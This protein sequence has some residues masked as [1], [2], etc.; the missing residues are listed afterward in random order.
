MA[1]KQ[2]MKVYHGVP[3]SV[4][5]KYTIYYDSFDGVNTT[6]LNNEYTFVNSPTGYG[7]KVSDT[8]YVG[9][10]IPIINNG[11]ESHTLECWFYSGTNSADIFN[12]EDKSTSDNL[13]NRSATLYYTKTS[14]I[15]LTYFDIDSY[16]Q[17]RTITVPNT[18]NIG[19]IHVRLTVVGHVMSL[20]VNGKLHSEVLTKLRPFN[21]VWV[22]S[23]IGFG[24]S[25][26]K[27]PIISDLR[28]SNVDRGNYFPNLPQDF[29][30]GKAAIK[31][32]MNQQQIKGD[33]MYTQVTTAQIPA[34]NTKSAELYCLNADRSKGYLKGSPEIF[35]VV[36]ANT[37]GKGSSFKIRGVNGEVVAGIVD[38]NAA[39]CKVLKAVDTNKLLVDSVAKLS[40]GDRLRAVKL[41]GNVFSPNDNA[42]HYDVMHIDSVNRI[43]TVDRPHWTQAAIDN[44][45]T[46]AFEITAPS[47]LPIVKTK[48]GTV[49]V[50]TWNGLGT[51]TAMFTLGVNPDLTG[52]DLYVE[53][54]LTMMH[55]NSDFP[56]LPSVVERAW[57]EN[58]VEMK[59]ADHL[60][61]TDDF[62]S[63]ARGDD[64]ICSHYCSFL[65]DAELVK[66]SVFAADSY[67]DY[68][69]IYE[70]DSTIMSL[71][72][73]SVSGN[74]GQLLLG[75]NLID[76][77]EK[78]IGRS[79]PS[80]D[81]IQ[82]LKENIL[83][84]SCTCYCNGSS[85]S[86]D[87][88]NMTHYCHDETRW[89][90][91][92]QSHTS[93]ALTKL[94]YTQRNE[95][96]NWMKKAISSTGFIHFV[97][98]TETTNTATACTI[99]IS[100]AQISIKL[101]T[102]PNHII[103]YCKNTRSREDVCNPILIQKETKTVKRYLPSNECFTTESLYIKPT[104][105]NISADVLSNYLAKEETFL[106]TLGSGAYLI[107]N[108]TRFKN[109]I[110]KLGLGIQAYQY[111]NKP[112]G[113]T[114]VGAY[115]DLYTIRML[116]QPYPTDNLMYPPQSIP[117]IPCVL[118]TPYLLNS[119][120]ELSLGLLVL[121]LNA[122]GA[123]TAAY[124]KAYTLPNRPLIK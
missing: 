39:L 1:R 51:K 85:P 121:E 97:L 15:Q 57:G 30:N 25:E 75:F 8:Q 74:K 11:I 63:K 100:Y 36:S 72:N 21:S 13:K 82:W 58:G 119:G 93:N 112:L 28:I 95:S 111:D 6:L 50:G 14:G 9:Y 19:W 2:K 99:R 92:T 78:K 122:S 24:G 38:A 32:R 89:Y 83:E 70:N 12:F 64:A 103:L 113:K 68:Y 116:S 102:D 31:P 80:A 56:E 62:K 71:S 107:H 59:P 37:W 120:G 35:D 105:S 88:I 43:I 65:A 91:N 18:K 61:I 117:N 109:C 3:K 54:S 81:K 34:F 49:V 101:K 40:V 52:Q 29:I 44:G 7:I 20:Y 41:S 77:V 22:G 42:S 76:I 104:T 98:F 110:D 23:Y 66:P 47:S 17:P 46:L 108:N 53:Y 115:T 124:T 87:K 114:T 79:I 86:G 48:D 5:D 94:Q 106:T 60:I 33:P 96:N 84:Y 10:G 123:R 45:Y 55:G 67:I 16:N 27:I 73:N 90:T 69:K 4:T 26:I 118:M